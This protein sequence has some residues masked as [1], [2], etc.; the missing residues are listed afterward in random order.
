MSR[1]RKWWIAATIAVLALVAVLIPGTPFYLPDL[2]V[3]KAQYNGHSA[4]YWVGALTHPDSE[5][6]QQ[7]TFNLGA[8][9]AQAAE[10]IPALARI[11]VDDPERK[12]RSQAALALSKMGPAAGA[13]VPA[14]AKALEDE[15][16]VVR[17]YAALDLSHLRTEARP[18]V[19]TLIKGL[20]DHVN[21][22]YFDSFMMTVREMMVQ[23]LG[24]ASAGTDEAVPALME[25]LKSADT[26]RT[27]R[28]AIR[29]LGDIGP[30][31]RS[32]VP[33]LQAIAKD[34]GAMHDI[35]Q[36]ALKKIEDVQASR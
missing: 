11:L 8:I 32:A 27:R 25:T 15:E 14:L 6:R 21:D 24:R 28:F 19:P 20:K 17:M 23:A 4:A 7:A 2:V 10:S 22:R 31:A 3:S 36:Q 12:V 26:Y 33:M 30:E 34:K 13:A 1:R 29:A 5:V 9:G 35:A 16:P 18:A